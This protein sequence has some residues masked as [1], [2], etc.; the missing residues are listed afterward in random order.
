MAKTFWDDLL[1]PGTFW[2][3]VLLPVS[4]PV[5]VVHELVNWL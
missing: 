3:W 2:F 4:L 1:D 5:Y